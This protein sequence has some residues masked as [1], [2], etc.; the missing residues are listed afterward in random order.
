MLPYNNAAMS[1]DIKDTAFPS[2]WK[3]YADAGIPMAKNV[4]NSYRIIGLTYPDMRGYK[5]IGPVRYIRPCP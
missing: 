2:V 5:K 3:R 1:A 4:N